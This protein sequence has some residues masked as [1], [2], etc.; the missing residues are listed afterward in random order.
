LTVPVLS[1]TEA[2]RLILDVTQQSDIEDARAIAEMLGDPDLRAAAYSAESRVTHRAGRYADA[3]AHYEAAQDLAD[4]EEAVALNTVRA[5][6][7]R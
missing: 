6:L 1:R 2:V 7:G 5:E 4:P 3:L